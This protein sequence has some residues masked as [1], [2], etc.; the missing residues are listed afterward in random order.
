[1]AFMAAAAAGMST[2]QLIGA[3]LSA[4]SAIQS[5]QA[6]RAQAASYRAQA[7]QEEL[8]GKQAALQYRQRG[9]ET[10]RNINRNISAVTAKAA[11]GDIDPY[12]G[13]PLSLKNY[14]RKAGAEEY[15]LD[16]ENASLA[17]VTGEMNRDQSLMAARQA[18]R[19][20]FYNAVGTLSTTAL[21]LGGL[22]GPSLTDTVYPTASSVG[23]PS[24]VS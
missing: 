2:L 11:A 10:L 15:Y 22:G 19:Q 5:I 14:A 24:M 12:S 16:Q 9:V 23:T 20:G 13:S 17:L 6:G 21:T 7:K 8:K 18:R 4:V 3:G 1:M